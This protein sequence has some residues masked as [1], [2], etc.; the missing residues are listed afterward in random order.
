M[1]FK[2]INGVPTIT[3]EESDKLIIKLPNSYEAIT[4][5][6]NGKKIDISGGSELIGSIIGNGMLEKIYIPPVTSSQ[7]IIDKCDKWLEMYRKIHDKF[8]E[9]VLKEEY[10][11]QNITMELS[12]PKINYNDYFTIKESK[13]RTIDLDLKQDSIIV[14]PGASIIIDE[15]NENVYAYLVANVIDYYV[16]NNYKEKKINNMSVN[17]YAALY[18]N[19]QKAKGKPYPIR[20]TLDP[21]IHSSELYNVVNSILTTHNLGISSKQIIDNLRNRI[22]NQQIGDSFDYG[23]SYTEQQLGYIINDNEVKE[24]VKKLTREKNK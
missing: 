7:D 16:Q 24:P 9:L 23:I 18:S 22:S 8:K 3:L 13:V 10:R 20:A 14:Q 17:F 21:L 4:I 11:E 5:K 1:K 6:R 15:A 12:F 19:E 2:D